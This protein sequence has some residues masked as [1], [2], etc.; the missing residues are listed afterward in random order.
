M[1]KWFVQFKAGDFDFEDK[2]RSAIDENL[3]KTVIED[4]PRSMSIRMYGKSK[5]TI[6]EHIMKLG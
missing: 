3:I 5:S 4:K 2:K 1:R 6:R